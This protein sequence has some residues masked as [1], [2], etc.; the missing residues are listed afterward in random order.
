MTKF[1]IRIIVLSILFVTYTFNAQ[2]KKIGVPF[3]TNYSP[4]TYKAASENWD[5]LQNSHGM[6]FFANHFGL[7]QFDGVRWNIVIQPKNKSMV[8]SLAIDKK[9][10]IYIGAQGDFGYVIQLPNGQ[11]SYTSLVKLIPF[12]SRNFGDVLHTIVRADEVIFFSNEGILFIKTI[13]SKSYNPIQ[14]LMNYLR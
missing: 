5:I 9:D 13:K 14:I 3:I 12:S 1:I 4:K 2:I 6:M 8:R 7:M 10:K 11:Y